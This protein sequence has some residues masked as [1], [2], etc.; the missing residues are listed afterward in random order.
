[1]IANIAEKLT[2][3]L[4]GMKN[5]SQLQSWR[6]DIADIEKISLEIFEA[7]ATSTAAKKA[8]LGDDDWLAHSVYFI[9][10]AL[11]FCEFEHAVSHADA[12]RVIQVF[13]Y[14]VFAFRGAGQHNYARECVEVLVKWKY[15][16]PPRLRTALEKSWFVNRWGEESRWIASDLYLEQLNFWVKVSTAILYN[17]NVLKKNSLMSHNQCVFI[18]QG[19][20]VMVKYIIEH[21]SVCVEAFRDISQCRKLFW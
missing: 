13:K 19:N 7:F 11:M 14:W 3:V 15:E 21:G 17:Y 4:R 6:P 18:A 10:D 1:M 16:L 8:K 5:W 2:R 20:G 9:R 12:G